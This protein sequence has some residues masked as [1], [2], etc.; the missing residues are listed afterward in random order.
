M[1]YTAVTAAAA[2]VAP[3][4]ATLFAQQ[5]AIAVDPLFLGF[6][7]RMGGAEV[8]GEPLTGR[9]ELDGRQV[10]LFENFLLEH[11]PEHSGTDYDVQPGLLGVKV[12]GNR[13]FGQAQPLR[14]SSQIIYVPETRQSLRLGF[15]SFWRDRGGVD[16]F[17]YPVSEEVVDDGITAQW[18]QRGKLTYAADRTPEIQIADLGRT[19]LSQAQDDLAATYEVNAPPATVPGGSTPLRLVITNSGTDTWAASGDAAVTV[20]FR[21]ADR[22]PPRD[23]ESPASISLPSDVAGGEQVE[24]NTLISLPTAPGQYRVQPDL[25]QNGEWFSAKGVATPTVDTPARLAEPEMR[26]GLLDI[27][28]DNPGVTTATITSTNGLRIVD[29]GG[30]EMAELTGGES[31]VIHRDIPG[32][33]HVL[34]LPDNERESTVGRVKVFPLEGSMLRLMEAAPWTTYRGSFEFIWLPRYSSAWLV[35]ILPLEDY[36]S[37]IAEQG[38][39][40]P[41]EALRASAIAFRS[42]A[43]ATRSERRASNLA[44]DAAGSTH[45]TP[46]MYTR[47]QVYHGMAR[48]FSGTRLRQAVADTRGQVMTYDSHTIMAVYFSRADGHTRSWHETWG[49]A[50]KPWAVGVPD[51]YSVGQTLLGHGIG[52]PLRS[53][54]AMAETGANGEQILASYYTDVDFGAIY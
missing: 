44:F 12:S 31:V 17:G 18:F 29:E 42:Y 2:G 6:Y 30:N 20:G 48:E 21:W 54:N 53:A 22:H 49:G 46:T 7:E 27:S 47:H 28:D 1:L 24:V 38:D 3:R 10:Q 50:F 16:L 8:F 36:L 11:W 23:R 51:P 52:L 37:G 19:W 14:D 32:E 41:W 13:Y 39:H 4:S 33:Q 9:Y 40:I 26:I 25:Q 35:N 45:H 34:Q 5:A 15:L 43:M